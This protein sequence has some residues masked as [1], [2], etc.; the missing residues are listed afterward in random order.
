MWL[1]EISREGKSDMVGWLVLTW[2]HSL[3]CL[4]MCFVRKNSYLV[5]MVELVVDNPKYYVFVFE[6][7]ST[8]QV[9][10]RIWIKNGNRM[11]NIGFI[12][13]KS[14]LFIPQF[15]VKCRFGPSTS[16]PD[17]L[18]LNYWN[19]PRFIPGHGFDRFW[20]VPTRFWPCRLKFAYLFQVRL[21]FSNSGIFLNT[22]TF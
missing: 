20:C 16:K 17:N 4:I 6:E 21:M 14:I 1:D 19:R 18:P 3:L 22:W 8:W 7:M 2:M 12:F 13:E 9:N 10:I 15:L 5:V 11:D